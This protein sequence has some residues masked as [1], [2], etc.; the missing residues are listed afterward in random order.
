M[1]TFFSL[2]FSFK[3][4]L[5]RQK[6]IILA[7]PLLFISWVFLFGS[8]ILNQSMHTTPNLSFSDTLFVLFFYS[9]WLLIMLSLLSISIRRLHDFNK[10]GW[11]AL[12]FFLPLIGFLFFLCLTYKKGTI[13]E[14]K[15]GLDPLQ[16]S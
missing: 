6:F 15:Y 9:S 8:S 12:I 2:F 4:R 16:Q 13:G 14:N 11:M 7:M 5:N 1:K 10:S 3:G